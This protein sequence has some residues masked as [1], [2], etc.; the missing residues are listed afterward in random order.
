[1][2]IFQARAFSRN[3]D[4]LTG[5][6]WEATGVSLWSEHGNDTRSGGRPLH[7]ELKSAAMEDCPDHR[8]LSVALT[9]K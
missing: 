7:T 3:V 5:D 8:I 4:E 1:M 9:L 6:A 2:S